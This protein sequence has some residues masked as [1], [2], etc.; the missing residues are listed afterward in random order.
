MYRSRHLYQPALVLAAAFLTCAATAAAQTT[1]SG[2]AVAFDRSCYA[3]G[4]AI[5]EHGQGFSPGGDV[6]ETVSLL[7]DL[8]PVATLNAQQTADASGNFTAMLRAPRLAKAS[9]RS[10]IALS[11][12]TD[13]ATGSPTGP[14]VT[15]WTLSAWDMKITQWRNRIADPSKSMSIDTY[16]WTTAGSNLYAH[17][18]RGTT[19]VKT[20]KIGALTG[21]C[22]NLKRRVRQFPFKRVKAGRWQVLFSATAAL[23]KERD[24]FI[25]RVVTV[26]KSKASG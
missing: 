13:Q 24:S 14:S 12:F 16:G 2:P 5:T 23:N 7:S 9:D 26:P 19:R 22:G 25:R 10:E 15:Q 21:E 1:P 11:A 17:Y 4:D 18:F 20:V 3:P 8:N 6:L